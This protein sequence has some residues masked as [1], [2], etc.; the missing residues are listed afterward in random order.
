M[1]HGILLFSLLCTC[2]LTACADPARN[3]PK[4]QA[5]CHQLDSLLQQVTAVETALLE[6]Q[7]WTT[8]ANLLR[9]MLDDLRHNMQDDSSEC[10]FLNLKKFPDHDRFMFVELLRDR[11]EQDTIPEGIYF[12]LRLRG[13]FDTDH[14]ISEYFSEELHLVALNNPHCFDTYLRT[15]PDQEVMLLY[16]TKWNPLD[17][18][19]LIAKFNR[20]DSASPAVTFLT[21]LKSKTDNI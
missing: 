5:P 18:D 7:D 11:T 21:D 12:L 3:T 16:S 9:P 10:N 13:I 15:N 14:D 8:C 4:A 2:L 17:L 6:D 19:T 20:I 1:R